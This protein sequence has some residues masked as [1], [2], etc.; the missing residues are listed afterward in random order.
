M[1]LCC[2]PNRL[3]T[4]ADPTGRSVTA[5]GAYNFCLR[6]VCSARVPQQAPFHLQTNTHIMNKYI[7]TYQT[8]KSTSVWII[9]F[10]SSTTI[11]PLSFIFVTHSLGQCFVYIFLNPPVFFSLSFFFF[12]NEILFF[13]FLF[14]SSY[15]YSLIKQ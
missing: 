12:Y 4:Q 11:L 3:E 9:P 7:H 15:I 14:S 6:V 10:T 8:C 13:N 1:P 5:T 2:L